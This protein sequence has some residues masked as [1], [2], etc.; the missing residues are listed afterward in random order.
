M[1]IH[2]AWY[3][4]AWADEISDAP[5]ARRICNEPVVLYR[6]AQNRVSALLDTC[7]H[8]GAPLHMGKVVEQGL[9]CGYHGLIFDRSGTCVRVPGQDRILPRTRV[10]SFPVVEQDAFV[11]IWMGDPAK[12]DPAKIVQW[13]WHNDQKNWPHKHTMYPIKAAAM[14]MVD[15]L[16]DL[17]HLGY[18]HASTIGGN[19]SQ[20]VEAKMETERTPLGLKFIRW[21]LNSVPPPTYVKAVGF[22]G[23]IDR[24]QRFEFVAPGSV[25]QW[26]GAGEV[27]AYRD[28]D[29]SNSK[30]QFRLFHGLTPETET[31]C[32]YFWSSANGF[33]QDDPAATQQLFDQVGAAFLEDKAVVEGQQARLTELGE[34][35]LVD[36]A[37]DAAR[38]HMRRTVQRLLAEEQPGE[39]VAAA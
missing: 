34:G 26:T 17:T 16:M 10:R 3:V 30:L 7:C 38:L 8:R 6:D 1:F 9:Q 29:T 24:C 14:L 37:T 32:F 23:R 22:Q 21:M 33:R 13:P 36:I 2:N 12:A 20:H 31:S 18:V 11:W 39:A 25:L 19:P 5:L 27:G 4:A 35:H 28:G 15:N